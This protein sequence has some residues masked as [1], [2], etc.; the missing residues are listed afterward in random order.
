MVNTYPGMWREDP[1]WSNGQYRRL[2]I[3]KL[4]V[5]ISPLPSFLFMIFHHLYLP[6][7]ILAILFPD[8]NLYYNYAG[9]VGIQ[10]CTGWDTCLSLAILG[11]KGTKYPA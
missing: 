1:F 5:Q 9:A 8:I 11:L 4:E 2:G 6:P 3:R 10:A 7:W